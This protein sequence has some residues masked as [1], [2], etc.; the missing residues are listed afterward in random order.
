MVFLLRKKELKVKNIKGS[1][2]KQVGR[3]MN[4]FLCD[5]DVFRCFG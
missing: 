1:G 5:V 2:G 4:I 3:R